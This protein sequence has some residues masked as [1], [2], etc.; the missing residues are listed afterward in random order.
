LSTYQPGPFGTSP[1]SVCSS[2]ASATEG[3]PATLSE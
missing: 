3:E 2:F 1:C